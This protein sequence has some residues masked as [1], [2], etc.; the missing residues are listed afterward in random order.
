MNL[1]SMNLFLKRQKAKS[2]KQKI[3][4]LSLFSIL[5]S[6]CAYSQEQPK[7]SVKSIEAVLISGVRAKDK[8]PITFTNVSKTQIA[9]RNLGQDIPILLNYL[10]SVVTTTD[11]GAGIGYT[12]MRVRGSDGSRINVT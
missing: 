4:K 1:R 10:P 7:D 9:P 8:N 3:Y 5:F 2:K 11:G 12:Y 6:L